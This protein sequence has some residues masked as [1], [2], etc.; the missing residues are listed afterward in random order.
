MVALGEVLTKPE[1][2]LTRVMCGAHTERCSLTLL[3][4]IV[5][6]RLAKT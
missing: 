3:D 4:S 5:P 6:A 1:W 2:C